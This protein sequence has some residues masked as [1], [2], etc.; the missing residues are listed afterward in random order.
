MLK[1]VCKKCDH[2]WISK[3]KNPLQCP[4]C[5]S[6]KWKTPKINPKLDFYYKKE[7]IKLQER[8]FASFHRTKITKI[9][10]NICECGEKATVNHHKTYENISQYHNNLKKYCEFLEPLCHKCHGKRP[11]TNYHLELG[12]TRQTYGQLMRDLKG[13]NKNKKYLKVKHTITL[14]QNLSEKVNKI[15]GFPKWRNN[16]SSVIEAALEDFL[17]NGGSK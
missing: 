10:G 6:Y 2:R 12:L 11:L 7:M 13:K 5:K 17:K 1:C 9:L 4:R 16:F 15:K 8:G 14:D 3:L